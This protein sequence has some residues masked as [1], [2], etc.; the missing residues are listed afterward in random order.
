MSDEPQPFLL[1]RIVM[2]VELD[3]DGTRVFAMNINTAEGQQY[4]PTKM[5]D[6][7]AMLGF[8]TQNINDP[9]WLDVAYPE[10]EHE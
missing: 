9:A 10:G 3:P 1:G 4:V 6:I 5:Y 2:T 7:H 8:A